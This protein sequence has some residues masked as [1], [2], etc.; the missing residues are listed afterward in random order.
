MPPKRDHS[1]NN[2]NNLGDPIATNI[3]ADTKEEEAKREMVR[4]MH[5]TTEDSALVTSR[6]HNRCVICQ[7]HEST[8]SILSCGHICLCEMCCTEKMYGISTTDNVYV[9]GV[10]ESDG[11]DMGEKAE[12]ISTSSVCPVCKE[13]SIGA[14]DVYDY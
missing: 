5:E 13:V 12:S 4:D 9:N 2:D 7:T 1:K 8:I 6:V 3:D 10:T 11:T 14:I